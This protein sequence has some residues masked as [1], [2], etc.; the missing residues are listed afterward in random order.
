MN[1]ISHVGNVELP[2][3]CLLWSDVGDVYQRSDDDINHAK[4][5]CKQIGPIVKT[6]HIAHELINIAFMQD[7][8][9]KGEETSKYIT[10]R[11][12]YD[13]AYRFI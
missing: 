8:N 10:R 4:K 13:I 9:N 6:A 11:V 12:V 7:S 3:Q 1:Q 2:N 5:S